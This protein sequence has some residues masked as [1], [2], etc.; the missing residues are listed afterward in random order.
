LHGDPRYQAVQTIPAARSNKALDVIVGG[1]LDLDQ[2][3]DVEDLIGRALPPG[4]AFEVFVATACSDPHAGLSPRNAVNR[5]SRVYR[6]NG[7]SLV[8]LILFGAL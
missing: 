7:P 6:A 3:Y 5:L 2:R 8:K 4:P 1:R